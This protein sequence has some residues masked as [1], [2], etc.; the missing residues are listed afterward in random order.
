MQEV[1]VV[2][3]KHD[4]TEFNLAHLPTTE[5]LGYDTGNNPL[6]FLMHSLLV[7]IPEDLPLYVLGMKTRV[8]RRKASTRNISEVME[9]H[10]CL[11]LSLVPTCT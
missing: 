6:N 3:A 8:R 7:F 4:T 1:P 9:P 10:E 5:G 11:L 2:L